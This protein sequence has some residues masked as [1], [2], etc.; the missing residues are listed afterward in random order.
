MKY[1]KEEANILIHNNAH[2]I[3]KNIFKTNVDV[4]ITDIIVAP[5][6]D[7]LFGKFIKEYTTSTNYLK[8]LE[9]IKNDDNYRVLV[10]SFN[11]F[12][13]MLYY[14]DLDKYQELVLEN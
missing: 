8:S 7:E 14:Q 6:S 5:S 11:Q 4:K 2:L 10:V 13:N 12:D 1:S 9:S 3:G